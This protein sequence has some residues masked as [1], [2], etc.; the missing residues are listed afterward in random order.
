MKKLMMLAAIVSVALTSCTK[1]EPSGAT[2]PEAISF[3][4]GVHQNTTRANSE[5]DTGIQFGTYAYHST[6]EAGH[7]SVIY[8]NNVEIGYNDAVWQA[9]EGNYYWPK[10]NLDFVSY[11]PYGHTYQPTISG[12]DYTTLTYTGVDVSSVAGQTDLLYSD[13]AENFTAN[14][15][16][17]NNGSGFGIGG[18]GFNGV[19]TLFHH[20]LAKVSLKVKALYTTDG[21][22]PATTWTTKIKSITLKD[23]YSSGNLVMTTTNNYS[24]GTRTW[25][26]PAGNVWAKDGNKTDKTW[27][28]VPA[29]QTL[30]TDYVAYD[31]ASNY[32]VLPQALETGVQKIVINYTIETDPVGGN[33]VITEHTY[34]MDLQNIAGAIASWQMGQ[35]IVYNISIDPKGE[36]ILFAPALENWDVVNSGD[37]QVKP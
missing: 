25:A 27:S 21:A 13:K 37:I 18:Y 1:D 35:S 33:N 29:G 32:Y 8:M 14:E 2:Q 23:I 6:T 11:A 31:V 22:T 30:T 26:K 34:E 7:A 4:V 16:A 5:F 10:G 19:P 9:V 3:E 36:E 28:V 15:I 17:A 20:A 24:T 12:T